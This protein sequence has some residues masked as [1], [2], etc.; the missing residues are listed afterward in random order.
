MI[1][2]LEGYAAINVDTMGKGL[3]IGVIQ[4]NIYC[5]KIYKTP[6]LALVDAKNLYEKLVINKEQ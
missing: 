3:W 2:V 6:K 4:G 5:K 1:K